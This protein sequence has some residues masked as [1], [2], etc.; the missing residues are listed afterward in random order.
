MIAVDRRILRENLQSRML[1][2]VHDELILEVLE[3]EL[4]QVKTLVREEM[5]GVVKLDV[6]L[7]VD[8]KAGVNWHDLK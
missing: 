3:N 6:P 5:E 2:Q 7:I 8:I 4:E 1:L